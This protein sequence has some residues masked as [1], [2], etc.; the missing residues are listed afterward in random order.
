MNES[1]RFKLQ[2]LLNDLQMEADPIA[3]KLEQCDKEIY[4]VK[5]NIEEYN[6]NNNE[7]AFVFSP[8]SERGQDEKMTKMMS[9][10]DQ[11][12]K[13]SALWRQRYDKLN[14]QIDFIIDIFSTDDDTGVSR[15]GLLYQEQDRQRIAR[16]LHDVTLQNMSYL[17]DKLENCSQY[18]DTDPVKAKMEL[19][20]AKQNLK[21]S[22]EEIRGIIYNLRPMVIDPAT[23][24]E[25]LIN[26]I[27]H[28]NEKKEYEIS[29]EIESFTCNNQLILVS[30]YRIIEECF[31]NIK[32]HAEAYKIHVIVQ[33]QVGHY[34]I[35]IEDDGKGFYPDQIDLDSD[36]HF[37][38]SIMKERVSLVGG[39]IK[40]DSSE[41]AG[42]KI[43]ILIP[44]KE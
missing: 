24:H 30:I 35:Y 14:S 29:S 23:F 41:N 42:T 17:A 19:S 39:T 21:E 34:Y 2:A 26:F 4:R 38:L 9:E 28:F 1:T 12:Q 13:E 33:E 44:I 25:L 5:Q 37:G 43:K 36:L 20:I 8:R 10:L 11:W 16:D 7:D 6:E 27:D 18:I 40:I 15:A 32:K 31:E 22:A 3:N